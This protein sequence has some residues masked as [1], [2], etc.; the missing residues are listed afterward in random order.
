MQLIKLVCFWRWI[1]AWGA[2]RG[3]DVSLVNMRTSSLL[4]SELPRIS[5]Q[6]LVTREPGLAARLTPCSHLSCMKVS[7]PRVSRV[8]TL[9]TYFADSAPT[10]KNWVLGRR[11]TRSMEH[12]GQTK[13]TKLADVLLALAFKDN[14]PIKTKHISRKMNSLV[15]KLAI[16]QFYYLRN[17]LH[18]LKVITSNIRSPY[19][20]CFIMENL[21]LW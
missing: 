18:R 16:M 13:L 15:K 11:W 5:I 2:R 12:L 19:N 17:I 9:A 14:D 1:T 4:R 3:P 20:Y 10:D 6:F 7:P 8:S 21:S